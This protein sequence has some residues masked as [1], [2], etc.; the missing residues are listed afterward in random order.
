MRLKQGLAI[1][2]GAMLGVATAAVLFA[3]PSYINVTGTDSI[4]VDVSQ[5][6]DGSAQ[7]YC[8]RDDGGRKIRFVLA[9]DG[10]GKVHSVIDACR[11]CY[12]YGRGYKVSDG[13]LVCRVCGNR[14]PLEHLERGKASC[15]PVGLPHTESGKQVTVKVSDLKAAGGFF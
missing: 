1:A 11:E 2:A 13:E 6:T 8:Y 4:Q 3:S 14:Y 15:V 9:R 10:Q 5:I 12:Q 7:E